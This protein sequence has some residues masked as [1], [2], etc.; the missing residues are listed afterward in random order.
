[1]AEYGK[2]LAGRL[3]TRIPAR[4]VTLDG[5]FRV[6]LANLSRSGASV[7]RS[8]LELTS[9]NA[10]LQWIDFEAFCHVRWNTQGQCGLEFDEAIADDWVLATRTYDA[11]ERLPD[12]KELSRRR[13]RDWVAG[14][15]RI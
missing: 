15:A 11:A 7:Y 5:E 1:M 10:I 12:D 3:K 14:I 2:R 13:A 4:L 8:G 9:G 6:V